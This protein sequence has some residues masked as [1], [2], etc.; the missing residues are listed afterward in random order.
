MEND[1]TNAEVEVQEES[2][3]TRLS[4]NFKSVLERNNFNDLVELVAKENKI[5]KGEALG[6]ATALLQKQVSI[7][8]YGAGRPQYSNQHYI[9]L[10]AQTKSLLK[11]FKN[12][13]E[14]CDKGIIAIQTQCNSQVEQ[15]K[16]ELEL[17]KTSH[18]EVLTELT[19][20]NKQ[21]EDGNAE[22]SEENRHIKKE[23]EALTALKEAHQ[24]AAE[25]WENEKQSLNEKIVSLQSLTEENANLLKER[26]TLKSEIGDLKKELANKKHKFELDLKEAQINHQQNLANAVTA[27]I[28]E[29]EEKIKQYFE[30][31]LA[32]LKTRLAYTSEQLQEERK[33]VEA[34]RTQEREKAEKEIKRLEKMIK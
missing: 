16:E 9:L 32:D 33:N 19:E 12:A 28:A 27:K 8:G 17:Q 13:L 4:L 18:D 21:L 3:Q 31:V 24:K 6:V 34:V 23:N 11:G 14:N 22:L 26:E 29:T 7:E 2:G 30:P 20:R 25:T 15:L 5:T 10:E 1:D